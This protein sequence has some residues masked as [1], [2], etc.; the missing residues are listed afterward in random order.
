MLQDA[1]HDV[2]VLPI[3]LAYSNGASQRRGE[4]VFGVDK[5]DELCHGFHLNLLLF[6]LTS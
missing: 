3:C 2:Q 6:C 4:L 5:K 1:N